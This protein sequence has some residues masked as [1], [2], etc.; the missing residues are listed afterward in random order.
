MNSKLGWDCHQSPLKLAAHNRIQL[1]WVPGHTGI[2]GNEKADQLARQGSSCQL[3]G[4]EPS[5]G[6]SAKVATGV[7]S[8]WMNKKDKEYWHSIHAHKQVKDCLLKLLENYSTRVETN[9]E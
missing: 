4:P 7:I 2:E 1:V 8:K 3:L 6:I 9:Y 5:L